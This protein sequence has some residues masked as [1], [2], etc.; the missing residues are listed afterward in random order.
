M[1]IHVKYD[2]ISEII[3]LRVENSLGE[4]LSKQVD[5]RNLKG[6]WSGLWLN[7]SGVEV[8]RPKKPKRKIITIMGKRYEVDEWE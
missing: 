7:F 8:T 2:P 4:D 3:K 6:L 1:Q 5:L